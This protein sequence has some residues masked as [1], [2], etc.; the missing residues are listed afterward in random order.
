[1]SGGNSIGPIGGAFLIGANASATFYIQT[2]GQDICNLA[3]VSNVDLTMRMTDG[4]GNSSTPLVSTPITWSLNVAP[5]GVTFSTGGKTYVSMPKDSGQSVTTIAPI[6][7]RCG[8]WL[9][10]VFYNNEASQG[11][12]SVL[13]VI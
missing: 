8:N 11:T 10:I 4:M 7:S 5:A 1:M 13:G 3:V 6:L 2:T 12:I 9:R